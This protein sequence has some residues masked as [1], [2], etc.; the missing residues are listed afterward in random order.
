MSFLG[1]IG[2]F[3]KLI[4]IDKPLY[5]II[6]IIVV[7]GLFGIMRLMW[8]KWESDMWMGSQTILV[9]FLLL[10][11][12]YIAFLYLTNTNYEIFH[13]VPGIVNNGAHTIV[14]ATN[15]YLNSTNMTIPVLLV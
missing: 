3:L 6:M 9:N 11:F 13:S 15:G 14:N 2:E 12:L 4:L 10:I 8:A 7:L 5:G 1:M